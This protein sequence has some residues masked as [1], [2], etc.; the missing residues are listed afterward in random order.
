[1][2]NWFEQ[3][4]KE[5]LAYAEKLVESKQLMADPKELVNEAYLKFFES[6]EQFDLIAVKKYINAFH[7]DEIALKMRDKAMGW[8]RTSSGNFAYSKKQV[9]IKGDFCCTICKE[10]KPVNAFSLKR[11]YGFNYLCKQCKSCRNKMTVAWFRK[12]KEKWNAYMRSRHIPIK[13]PAKPIHDLWKKANKKYQAKQK[14]NLTDVY[15][16]SIIRHK[17]K[18]PTP[19]Q[20]EAKRQELFAKRRMKIQ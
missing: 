4:Y 12:N 16:K 19:Q 17:I 20:I 14:E 3:Y 1:M 18:N 2:I 5:L 9:E 11:F 8:R 6:G 15:I 10:V 7:Y 13:K